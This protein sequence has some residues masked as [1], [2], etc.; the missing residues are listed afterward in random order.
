MYRTEEVPAVQI[1]FIL[2]C[3]LFFIIFMLHMYLFINQ[4]LQYLCRK[5]LYAWN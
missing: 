4:Q 1:T 5:D 2:S 3:P